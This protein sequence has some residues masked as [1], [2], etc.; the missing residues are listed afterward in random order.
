MVF[1]DR[2]GRFVMIDDPKFDAV[3]ELIGSRGKTLTGHIGEPKDCW[4][5]FDRMKSNSNRNYYKEHP[6]Y[7][8]FMHP[9]CPFYD[10][11]IASYTKMLEKHPKIRYVA[12]HLGSIEW[13]MTEL[14]K[15][16][17][18]FPNMVVD[19][20]ARIDDI[21]NLEREEVRN[22]FMKYKSRILYGTD[23][24]ISE[25]TDIES[26]TKRIHKRGTED[27]TYFSTDSVLTLE[28][29]DHPVQGLDLPT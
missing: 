3:I 22:F 18:R 23:V 8:M 24:I 25:N 20:S 17:D 14:G 26:F 10:E 29:I 12:C 1:K 21:Q 9:E 16:L 2:E 6:E 11:Q 28:G 4:L 5:P 13:S 7:H 15:V 19:C 27:W